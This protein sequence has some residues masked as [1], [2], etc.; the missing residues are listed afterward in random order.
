MEDGE[1]GDGMKDEMMETKF[2]A[3]SERWD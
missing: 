3:K 1:D 2:K